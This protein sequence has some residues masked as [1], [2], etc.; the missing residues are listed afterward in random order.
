LVRHVPTAARSG[1]KWTR[2]RY[3]P[4]R[5]RRPSGLPPAASL[6]QR[7]VGPGTWV[8]LP[9]PG[10]PGGHLP[11]DAGGQWCREGLCR[12]PSGCAR[13]A[14]KYDPGGGIAIGILAGRLAVVSDTNR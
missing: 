9:F 7:R 1:S 8:H 10:R 5:W 2:C 4:L 13:E 12:H 3:M 11:R 14:R 6:A